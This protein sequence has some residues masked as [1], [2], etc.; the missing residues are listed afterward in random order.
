MIFHL[1]C[2]KEFLFRW[3]SLE[4]WYSSSKTVTP[5]RLDQHTAPILR[6][7]VVETIHPPIDDL[8]IYQARLSL[9][10]GPSDPS[11]TTLV[12]PVESIPFETPRTR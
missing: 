7:R 8:L 5:A 6:S 2:A 1:R 10:C 4:F 9:P 3:L 12:A 11:H